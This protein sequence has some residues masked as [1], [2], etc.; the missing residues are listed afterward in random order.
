[1]LTLSCVTP[2]CQM[3]QGEAPAEQLLH[4]TSKLLQAHCKSTPWPGASA[5]HFAECIAQAACLVCRIVLTLSIASPAYFADQCNLAVH[6]IDTSCQVCPK[7][8][9]SECHLV[10]LLGHGALP[11]WLVLL[12]LPAWC[13]TAS[14]GCPTFELAGEIATYIQ[15]LATASIAEL[16]YRR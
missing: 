11:D 13:T 3:P 7:L 16:Q 4:G 8:Y 14:R 10:S 12:P 1:M 2:A 15:L 6:D 5:W 9:L